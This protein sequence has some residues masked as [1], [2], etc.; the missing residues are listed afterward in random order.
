[1]KQK[2]DVFFK[3][4]KRVHHNVY[5]LSET[6]FRFAYSAALALWAISLSDIFTVDLPAAN[7]LAITSA[8]FILTALVV[9]IIGPRK[10]VEISPYTRQNNYRFLG[11]F[12]LKGTPLSGSHDVISRKEDAD[13]VNRILEET[14]FPQVLLKQALCITGPSGSGKST[15]LAFFEQNYGKEYKI[16]NFSGNYHK[17]G[18]HME[19]LFG[20][21]IDQKIK[22][23]ARHQKLVFILDQFER[24]FFLPKKDQQDIRS[25]IRKFCM[26]NTA[27]IITLREEYLADFLKMF[28]MNNLLGSEEDRVEQTGVLREMVSVVERSV[29]KKAS[30]ISGK[31]DSWNGHRIKDNVKIHL[32]SASNRLDDSI[33]DQVGAA[34]LYC[35]NQNEMMIRAGGRKSESSEL[36]GK[37]VEILGEERGMALFEKHANEPLIQQQ[38]IYH[39][40]E[41]NADKLNYND[42]EKDKFI[43]K[44]NNELFEHYFDTQLACC[45]SFFHSSRILYLLSQARLHQVSIQTSDIENCLFPDLLEPDGHSEMMENIKKL[46]ELQLIRKNT[47]GSTLEYEI[48][49]DFISS[50]FIAYCSTNMNRGV[51]NALD[52]FISEFVNEKRQADFKEKIAYRRQAFKDCFF[53][54]VTQ[55]VFVIMVLIH[56]VQRFIYNPWTS[57]WADWNPYGDYLPIFPLIIS[58]LSVIYLYVM[59][60]KTV[61]YYRGRKRQRCRICFVLYMIYGTFSVAAYPHFLLILG[62]D[63]ALA[64]LQIARLLDQEYKQSC[65]SELSAYGMKSFMIG[66]VMASAHFLFFMFNRHFETFLIF[67]EFA[68]F[69]ILVA[70]AYVVH[71]HQEYMFARMTDSASEKI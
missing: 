6:A 44:N 49:H 40:N 3:D 11:L 57:V 36:S 28:D 63:L 39:M 24:F 17:L 46:E 7:R 54:I 55:V 62:S 65:R 37:L 34:L 43:A 2:T 42:E 8:I 33:L 29:V 26:E 19:S 31:T 5:G 12:D 21:D 59:F 22:E 53:G 70:Y 41:F 47:E 15:I 16:Y 45:P 35:R 14:L 18:S 9:F 1:M 30:P 13:Y 50:M 48:A 67:T 10:K 27:V 25:Y 60:D 32:I 66:M 68:M 69:T 64:T 4:M 58:L 71:M 52:L 23:L 20:S 38:I 56:L 51:K 61:K